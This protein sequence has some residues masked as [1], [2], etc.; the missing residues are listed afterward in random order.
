[1]RGC[2]WVTIGAE[3][4]REIVGGLRSGKYRKR[5]CKRITR[6]IEEIEVVGG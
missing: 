2:R 1:M 5:G 6:S 3:E 4:E